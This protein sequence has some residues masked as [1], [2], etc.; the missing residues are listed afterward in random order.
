VKAI[1]GVGLLP[2][3]STLEGVWLFWG[4]A[5]PPGA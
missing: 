4:A 1:G 2:W 5:K 3:D